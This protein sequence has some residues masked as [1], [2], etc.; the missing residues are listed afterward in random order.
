MRDENGC[1]MKNMW[2]C[3]SVSLNVKELYERID[4][5]TAMYESETWGMRLWN[6]WGPG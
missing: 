3:S 2:S 5:P 4:V 1:A 6:D